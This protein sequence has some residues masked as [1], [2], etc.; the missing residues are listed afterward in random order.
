MCFAGECVLLLETMGTLGVSAPHIGRA[1]RGVPH[2][3]I[4]STPTLPSSLSLSLLLCSYWVYEDD[5]LSTAHWSNQQRSTPAVS[6]ITHSFPIPCGS[7]LKVVSDQDAGVLCEICGIWY[8]CRCQ[9]ISDS[10]YKAMSQYSNDLHWFCKVCK[11]GAEKLL[12][13]VTKVQMKVERL[14]DEIV[15]L[16]NDITTDITNIKMKQQPELE[17]AVKAIGD[18]LKKLSDRVEQC[19]MVIAADGQ[20]LHSNVSSKL[21]DL[22]KKLENIEKKDTPQ[23]SDIVSKQVQAVQDT[24]DKTQHMINEQKSKEARVNN[25]IIYNM[26]EID[27]ATGTD[28]KDWMA[29]ERAECMKLFNDNMNI[30]VGSDDIKR[31]LRLGRSEP[32]KS[33]PVLVEFREKSTKNLIMESAHK[34]RYASYPSNRVVTVM[35]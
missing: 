15:R 26:P 29:E 24:F 6:L 21:T 2:R 8:H 11:A 30:T 22:E 28:R 1:R 19:E 25:I 18:D 20:E 4:G 16:K 5:I 23:W 9:G 32:G 13:I 17:Q 12:T 33:R 35:I 7:C 34:L 10:L 27:A 14:E 31:M 3:H